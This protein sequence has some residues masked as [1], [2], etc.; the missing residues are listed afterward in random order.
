MNNPNSQKEN[1][2]LVSVIIPAYNAEE[3]LE[4]A[5]K[6]VLIQN[7]SLELIVIN[8]CSKDK[9]AEIM[10][11]YADDPCIHY[12]ENIVRLG[13]SG[14]RNKGVSLARGKYVA[15]LD[16]D[17]WWEPDKLK[18]Q[19]NMMKKTGAVMCSTARKL[20]GKTNGA[21]NKIIPVEEIIT[22]E[23]MLHQNYINCSSVLIQNDVIARYPMH[24]E[25]S[26]EDYITWL[27]ILKEYKFAC[28][29]NEPLLNY[30]VSNTG[31]SGS[32][33]QSAKK[34]FMVYRHMGFG[35]FR[36]IWYFCCYAINGIKKY[37]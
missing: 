18:K 37:S 15:F 12:Y 3:T 19:L 14:T 8:D 25:N 20:I 10:K 30:R 24:Y 16:C 35:L 21:S 5:I 26:H 2:I 9:T 36:C 27:K 7:V 4:Q 22:Y 31:K 1:P 29:I 32:K 28:A 13:A 11:K 17:D 6:S 33:L 34:T 23:M